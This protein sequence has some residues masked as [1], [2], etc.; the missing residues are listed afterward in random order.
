MEK[1]KYN[2]EVEFIKHHLIYLPDSP[3]N[4]E[5]LDEL[6]AAFNDTVF[7]K[8]SYNLIFYVPKSALEDLYALE[9]FMEY[10]DYPK[11]PSQYGKEIGCWHNIRFVEKI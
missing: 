1:K 8:G 5:Y 6:A 11:K 10:E 4:K 7:T 9:G 3:I 2:I